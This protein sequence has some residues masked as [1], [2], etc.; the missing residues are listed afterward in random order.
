MCVFVVGCVFVCV[1]AHTCGMSVVCVCV[2]GGLCVC[3]GLCVVDVCARMCTFL[4]L[5]LVGSSFGGGRDMSR[6][7]SVFS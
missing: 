3:D 1:Y 6:C 2:R 5:G 7:F 4:M